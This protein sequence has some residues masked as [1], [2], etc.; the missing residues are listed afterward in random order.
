M[1]GG[2]RE[3]EV[4]YRI[5]DLPALERALSD[6]GV[7][8]SE[9]LCQDDQAYAER[10]WAY[11]EPKVGVTFARLRTQCGRHLFTV[12]RPLDNEMACLEHETEV[13]D[14]VAMH[15]AVLAMGFV[16]TVRIVKIRRTAAIGDV[17]V[18]VDDVERAG[19][20]LELERL[21]DAGSGGL[22]VQAELDGI[23]RSLGVPMQRVSD[24]Y[25]SLVRAH[26]VNA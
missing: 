11:G 5:G 22:A 26:A 15:Q 12:K 13:A 4:K 6:R 25:D 3:I 24:T 18:C 17:A 1:P 8:L 23:A 16:P 20:F 7:V 2:L 10:G 21:I 9:P 14:R 19:L